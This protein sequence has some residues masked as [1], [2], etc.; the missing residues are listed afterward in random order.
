MGLKVHSRGGKWELGFSPGQFW[1]P[2]SMVAGLQKKGQLQRNQIQ[3]KG[4]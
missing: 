4:L 3:R 1:L 2:H